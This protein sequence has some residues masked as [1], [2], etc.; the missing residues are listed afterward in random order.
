MI[1]I[2]DKRDCCGCAACVQRCPKRCISLKEDEEGFLYPVADESVCI[3]CGLCEKVCPI[4][5][6]A[7]KL[8]VKEVLAVKNRD[9][10]E[11]MASSSG[12]VFIALAKKTMEKGGVVF[13]AVFDENWEVRHTYAETLDCVRP[14]MG[15]KYVQSRIE[16]SYCEAEKFLKQGREVLFTGSPCQIAGLHSYLRKDYPNLLAV[17]FLCHGVPSPGVWRRYLREALQD[18]VL[19]EAAEKN[20]VLSSSLKSVPVITGIEFRDKTH[21]GWKKYSFVVRGSA[22]KADK[23]SVLLSDI[24]SDNPFMRGF[25]A[26]IYLRPSCYR[27]L[28]KN[29]VSHSDLT[30]GDFWGI[31]YLMPDFDDDKGVGLVLVST[32][33]GKAV[34]DALDMEVRGAA[35][36]TAK[37]YNGGFNEEITQYY[38]RNVFYK[39]LVK[40]QFVAKAVAKELHIP[41]WIRGLSKI[42][43]FLKFDKALNL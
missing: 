24:H 9:E 13:G 22:S 31:D 32:D 34:F 20:T 40:G 15:S 26:N 38:N 4:I 37:V 28:C 11:R 41:L 3:N 35:I 43:G 42:A 16:D 7:E 36:E 27:C 2:K 29:G 14:M 23:N 1:N 33:K 30:I 39:S 8:P 10:A 18:A 12:G 5:N 6:R 19:R 21:C 25:L 17:D